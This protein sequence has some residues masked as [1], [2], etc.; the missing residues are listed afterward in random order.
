[1]NHFYKP[2]R[3]LICGKLELILSP[4]WNIIETT[5]NVAKG[6]KGI[7]PS[8]MSLVIRRVPPC[9]IVIL[10]TRNLGIKVNCMTGF[11][12]TLV[13]IIFL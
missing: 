7:V 4:I 13:N 6:L 9:S 10:F 5:V 8:N 11:K 12:I 2:H 1:M 3:Y